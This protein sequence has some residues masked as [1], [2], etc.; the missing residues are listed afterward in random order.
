MFVCLIAWE[1]F[2]AKG[3]E[4]KRTALRLTGGFFAIVAVSVFVLWCFYGFRYS[5]APC[6]CG[7]QHFGGTIRGASTAF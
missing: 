3:V 1:V 2:T 4:R 5:C 6:G 7:V